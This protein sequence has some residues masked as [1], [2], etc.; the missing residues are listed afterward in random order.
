MWW[1]SLLVAWAAPAPGSSFTYHLERDLDRGT[2]AY[3]G[4]TE[5]LQADGLYEVLS[6]T[7]DRMTVRARY[8]WHFQSSDDLIQVGEEDRTVSIDLRTRK[9]L[10]GIDLDELDK[11]RFE[12]MSAWFWIPTTVTLG[13]V[14]IVLDQVY[15]VGAVDE[16]WRGEGAA[17]AIRLDGSGTLHRDDVYGE[18]DYQWKESYW[19]D[20]QTGLFLG[21]E[22]E[23]YDDGHLDGERAA[24]NWTERS[25]RRGPKWM[26]VRDPAVMASLPQPPPSGLAVGGGMVGLGL[27]GLTLWK[28]PGWWRR[29]ARASITHPTLGRVEFVAGDEA[30]TGAGLRSGPLDAWVDALVERTVGASGE[31][32][33][34]LAGGA[35]VGVG[36]AE[37]DSKVGTVLCADAAVAAQLVRHIDREEWFGDLNLSEVTGDAARVAET[38]QVMELDAPREH[39]FDPS[40]VRRMQDADRAAVVALLHAVGGEKVEPWLTAQLDAGDEGFVAVIDGA[41]VGFGLAGL[42]G[43]VGRLHALVVAPSHRGR[44]VGAEL[45]RARVSAM[46]VMGASR[47]ISEIATWN[48]AS[49]HLAREVGFQP[50]GELYLLTLKPGGEPRVFRR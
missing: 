12:V 13:E 43:D 9:Y 35:V 44:G 45:V 40:L 5:H 16:P 14:V 20:S 1:W 19:Y 49:T 4:Y 27:A 18:F 15:R 46:A 3:A 24:F 37:P 26:G 30:L 22:Y 11:D 23:E 32:V 41:V 42:A 7:P 38:W 25:R 34:A 2:G 6:V 47:V 33:V 36:L 31:V 50:R 10:D 17:R 39:P 29:R 21:S 28:L 8:A 48:L